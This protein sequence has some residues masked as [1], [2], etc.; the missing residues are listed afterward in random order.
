L[1]EIHQVE[2]FDGELEKYRLARGDLLVVEGNGSPDQI[3]R[4]GSWRGEIENAVHQ[5]HLIRVRPGERLLPRY[6]ELI[7]NSPL[8]IDQ[9]RE[10]ARSTSG[11]YTLSTSKVKAV[12]IP[13]PSL[14]DQAVLVGKADTWETCVGS[15]TNALRQATARSE[16][17][18]RSL[19]HRAFT[20][21]LVPQ[22]PD[23]EPASVLLDRIRAELGAQS[24]KPQR[25]RW[26]PAKAGGTAGPSPAPEAKPIPA[27]AVQ[28][29]LPL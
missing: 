12:R 17:L 15:A 8:V 5:N 27:D 22:D 10:V 14:P 24:V 7:W 19:L 29:E 21:R 2:L 11:L 16:S 9:L 18:R 13:V 23:D 20:G 6:L 3:G 4:A 25:K 1:T 28:Q 26:A